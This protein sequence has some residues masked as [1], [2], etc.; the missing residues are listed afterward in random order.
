MPATKSVLLCTECN[1]PLATI[2]SVNG[3]RVTKVAAVCAECQ[4]EVSYAEP[5]AKQ[6][7]LKRI[8]P[9]QTKLGGGSDGG[10]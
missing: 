4:I 1:D 9:K 7:A 2:E 6:T 8:D 3:S 5:K 10:K